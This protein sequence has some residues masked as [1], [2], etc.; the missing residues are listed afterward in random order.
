MQKLNEIVFVS[1]E[2]FDPFSLRHLG[3]SCALF[4][5]Q[6]FTVDSQCVFECPWLLSP[7]LE[8]LLAIGN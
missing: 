1:H 2:H 3:G 7:A 8:T 4:H 5:F 6:V